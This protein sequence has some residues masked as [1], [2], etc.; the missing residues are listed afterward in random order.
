[1]SPKKMLFA[2]P[3]TVILFFSASLAAAQCCSGDIG[4]LQGLNLSIANGGGYYPPPFYGGYGYGRGYYNPYDGSYYVGGPQLPMGRQE[5]MAV[6]AGI[7][8]AIGGGASGNWR[9]SAIGG[10]IGALAGLI[11]GREKN[12]YRDQYG[13]P[14]E[15]T[16]RPVQQEICPRG[17]IPVENQTPLGIEVT[18]DNQYLGVVG[19]GQ[20]ICLARR[21]NL[22]GVAR[23]EGEVRYAEIW[24]T[25]IGLAFRAP[26]N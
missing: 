26:N 3:L 22:A 5:R 17:T 19:P 6:G 12:H 9:G 21:G 15:Q 24:T 1:M 10:G 18:N 8:A 14:P 23:R 7:G 16:R 11:V 25:P 20:T 13:R 4:Y 2:L